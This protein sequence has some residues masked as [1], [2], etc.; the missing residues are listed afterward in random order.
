[1]GAS[2]HS[3]ALVLGVVRR[4]TLALALVRALVL[5][6]ALAPA[7]VLVVVRRMTLALALVLALVPHA[8]LA[9]GPVPPPPL[10]P[11]SPTCSTHG[12]HCRCHRGCCHGCCGHG[13]GLCLCRYDRGGKRQRRELRRVS[14]S[15]GIMCV[16][17]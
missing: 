17:V 3:L 11:V 16:R 13:R 6:L 4:M 9:L 10:H 5:D 7:L 15:P 2:S 14:D 1:M 8:R 12:S